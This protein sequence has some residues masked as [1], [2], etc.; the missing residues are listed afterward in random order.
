MKK[1]SNNSEKNKQVEKNQKLKFLIFGIF[2]TIMNVYFL[3]NTVIQNNTRDF[4]NIYIILLIIIILAEI[5]STIFLIKTKI[6]KWKIENIFLAIAIPTGLLY[7]FVIPIGLVPDEEAHFSRAYEISKGYLISD[8]NESGFGG[9]ELPVE[10]GT[11]MSSTT[12][13]YEK[14]L[15][16]LKLK[17]SGNW[18]FKV[19]ANTASYSFVCY[20][21]QTL[22]ILAGKVLH[23][24]MLGIA[25]FGR[26]FNLAAW[27]AVMYVALKLIPC[28]KKLFLIAA[29][30]PITMQEAASLSADALTISMCFLLI[31]YVIYLVK[32]KKSQITKKEYILLLAITTIVSLCKIV[33]IPF[34]LL[35]L[36][37]PKEKFKDKNDKIKKVAFI[38]AFAILINLI[39]LS[40]GSQF[41]VE[42]NPGVDSAEQVKYILSHPFTYLQVIANTIIVKGDFIAGALSKNLEIFNV[43]MPYIFQLLILIMMVLAIKKDTENEYWN[44]MDKKLVSILVLGACVLLIFT[45]LYV[46]WTPLKNSVIDG[47]QGRYFIPLLLLVPMA[48]TKVTDK[49]IKITE[50]GESWFEQYLCITM[51]FINI[52][53]LTLLFY[54]HI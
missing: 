46:Q 18:E 5:V 54:T 11:I 36:L 30:L 21:P 52:A 47:I 29:L 8:K 27:I 17:N 53:A 31:S 7:M 26:L 28:Y 39:W 15:D 16:N 51:I 48:V 37:I 10:I 19:F 25:Y 13:T 45:S 43:S 6:N 42:F 49:K 44:S 12:D 9:R 14:T 41:L 34:C 33:Y 35:L 22:G 20:I 23:L 50:K 38:I 1:R 24:P 40:I 4:D 32:T 3:N 2:L